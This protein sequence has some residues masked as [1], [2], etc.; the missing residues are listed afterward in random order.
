MR[1]SALT[2]AAATISD[3]P[4][5]MITN[6]PWRSVK[7]AGLMSQSRPTDARAPPRTGRRATASSQIQLRAGGSTNDA[8]R[9]RTRGRPPTARPSGRR[10]RRRSRPAPVSMRSC[11][12]R[13]SARTTRYG[14]VNQNTSSP[15]APVTDAAIRNAA[16]VAASVTT[17]DQ[18]VVGVGRVQRPREL[19]PCPPDQPEQQ[20]RARHAAGVEVGGGQHVT[21]VTANT[22]TRSKNSSTNVTACDSGAC[23]RRRG[24]PGS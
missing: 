21:C 5:A 20:H 1:G 10:C 19:G 2:A 23:S 4:S 15:N 18:V 13:P 11:R 17:A 8:A 6:R 9:A 22:N 12:P 3:S 14:M 16:A 7:C 24:I